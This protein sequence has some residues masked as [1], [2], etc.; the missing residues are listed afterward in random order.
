M[1][2]G[3]SNSSTRKFS[4]GRKK[5]IICA[6]RR[7]YEKCSCVDKMEFLYFVSF[8]TFF[9]RK[10]AGIFFFLKAHVHKHVPLYH[11]PFLFDILLY[12]LFSFSARPAVYLPRA[13]SLTHHV[14]WIHMYRCWLCLKKKMKIKTEKRSKFFFLFLLSHSHSFIYI[15]ILKRIRSHTCVYVI[16]VCVCA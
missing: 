15:E 5:K 9:L 6:K 16:F 13:H 3:S 8:G 11:P 10:I 1:C 14:E 4:H 12:M 7:K 2:V